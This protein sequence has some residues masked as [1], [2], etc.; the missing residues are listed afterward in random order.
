MKMVKHPHV[1]KLWEV[2]ASRSKVGIVVVVVLPL[3]PRASPLQLHHDH[4]PL[5]RPPAS[6]SCPRSLSCWS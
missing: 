6:S 3:R 4:S 2:L 5:P 1:V